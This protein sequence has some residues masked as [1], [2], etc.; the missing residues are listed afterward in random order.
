MVEEDFA[1][2]DLLAQAGTNVVCPAGSAVDAVNPHMSVSA[3][4]P[5]I[6]TIVN[7]SPLSAQ[8]QGRIILC[9]ITV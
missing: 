9:I 2:A 4:L 6:I 8:D 3:G 5:P 7:A 1:F